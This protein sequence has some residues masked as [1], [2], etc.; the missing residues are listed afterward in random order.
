M[1]VVALSA[2]LVVSACSDDG[3]DRGSGDAT[4]VT[5][6]RPDGP[7]ADLSTE[8]TG[9]DG[10]FVGS[11]EPDASLGGHVEEEF[12]AAGTATAFEE[13]A[14]RTEDGRWSFA[15]A[16]SAPYRTRVLVRRPENR[17]D[18]SGTVLVE[19]LNVSGGVDADPDYATLREEILRQ[20]H[21]WVGVSA[22]ESGVMGGP[23][24]VEAPGGE[25]IAGEGLRGIDP[26]RY[27][28]LD[29]PGDSFA[30]DIYTQVARAVRDGAA[31]GGLEPR[32]LL[33]AGESQSAFALVTYYNGVQPLTRAFDGFFVHSRGAAGFPLVPPGE[34]ADIARSI[35]GTAT[36]FRTDSD[37][38]VMN[39]QAEG[40]V[41]SVIGSL[42]ARQPDDDGFRLWEVAGTAH[43][44]TRLVGETVDRL[45][46]GVPINDGPLHVVAKAALRG[47]DA[48]VRTGEPPPR[49]PRLEIVPGE[50]EIRRDEVG[51]AIGGVRT[52]PV[53]VPVVVLSGEPGPN[54]STLCLLLGSMTPLTPEQLA[55]RY[56]SR[57][58]YEDRYEAAVDEAIEAGFVV[59]AD[60]EA[61]LAYAE[62]SLV[63]E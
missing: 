51:I 4:D 33:A 34:S 28:S 5:S 53:D 50:R 10:P 26:V 30:F 62:P 31:M 54:P 35:G 20:G 60:R 46:C 23:V 47:L 13:E 52:P 41:T 22:Q 9:G 45:D 12:A 17:A 49:A 25:G 14:P 27:G 6:A 3:D 57:A 37:A 61:L 39:L 18:F 58:E 15:P 38:P 24:L 48:W 55:A 11:A 19:W 43:A 56:D 16:G 36:I 21:A 40:D 8:L 2:G 32:R 44:D 42:P 7:A 63:A 59:P 1:L 29:H